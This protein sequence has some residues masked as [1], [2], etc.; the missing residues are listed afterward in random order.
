METCIEDHDSINAEQPM[1]FYLLNADTSINNGGLYGNE[2]SQR[3]Y[4]GSNQDKTMFTS[5][6]TPSAKAWDGRDFGVDICFIKQ[7][8]YGRL[9]FTVN[10]RIIGSSQL[11]STQDY[12]V[13]N[14]L[15][16]N[17][18]VEWSYS[19]D[20]AESSRYPALR[21]MGETEGNGWSRAC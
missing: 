14:E 10:P 4:S 9:S 5:T 17:D 8:D 12:C 1:K 11:C 21:F 7:L 3:A 20:I 13:V 18:I 16:E 6:T 19:T 2:S 15:P